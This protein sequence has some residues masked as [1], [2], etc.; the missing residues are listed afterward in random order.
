M[1][2]DDL[3]GLLARLRAGDVDE[4][5]VLERLHHLPYEDLGYAQVDH[6][7]GVFRGL[8]EAI[9]AGPKSVEQVTG[10]ARAM[11]QRSG[12]VIATRVSSA[13]AAALQ[14]EIP[15]GHHDSEARTFCARRVPV[16][17][18]PPVA[19]VV[20]GTSD[21][22]VAAEAQRTLEHF[23]H[24]VLRIEDCGVAGLHRLTAHLDVLERARVVIAVA[25]MEGALPSVVGGLIAAPVIAVPT[26]VGYGAAFGGVAALLGML[27]SCAQ[28]V[29]V[30][31]I[32]NGFGAACAAVRIVR[33]GL[34]DP[35]PGTPASDG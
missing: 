32:D 17:V 35:V 12:S 18:Q 29:V 28:G 19:V 4:E 23:G 20:A 7:R 34:R 3:R 6:H 2:R 1:N 9:L 8:D 25:G 27:N 21:R 31:N 10:I 11:W 24:E 33:A 22:P 14:H 16:A 13:Q 30:V 15:E 5:H 26:S